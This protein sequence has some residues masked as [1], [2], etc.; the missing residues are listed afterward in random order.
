MTPRDKAAI[1]ARLRILKG[2]VVA[3]ERCVERS[4]PCEDIIELWASVRAAVTQLAI[5]L[6]LAEMK[7]HRADRSSEESREQ[8]KV[9][10]N[11][12]LSR[13]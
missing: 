9:M 5:A 4:A 1:Q 12:F 13:R 11:E 2:Q 7:P 8:L 6:V 10:I 3:I